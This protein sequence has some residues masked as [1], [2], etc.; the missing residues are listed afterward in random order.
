MLAKLLAAPG[1][2]SLGASLDLAFFAR[3]PPVAIDVQADPGAVYDFLRG[4]GDARGTSAC[5]QADLDSLAGTGISAQTLVD[6]G[7]VRVRVDAGSSDLGPDALAALK[8]YA[9]QSLTS[10]VLARFFV[11]VPGPGRTT[12]QRLRA[13][14]EVLGD[15]LALTVSAADVVEWPTSPQ[16]SNLLQG[17]TAADLAS[18]VRTVSLGDP[19]WSTLALRVTAFADFGA[20]PIAFVQVDIEY[21]GG[22]PARTPYRASLVFESS[23]TTKTLPE[24][25]PLVA[26]VRTYRYQTKIAYVGRDARVVS[27][28]TTTDR[29]DLNVWAADPAK[30]DLTVLAGDVDFAIVRSVVAVVAYEDPAAGR[31]EH[32]LTLTADVRSA[33]LVRYLDAPLAAP[34]RVTPTFYLRD[35]TSLVGDPLDATTNLV[36]VGLPAAKTL[37]VSLLASG[38]L[39]D[40]AQV[41]VELTYDD[42][43]G[44]ATTTDRRLSSI[45]DLERWT[46]PLR[47]ASKDQFSYSIE[48]DYH[49]R[50]PEVRPALTATGSQAIVVEV[51]SPPSLRVTVHPELVDFTAIPLVT[52]DLG[53]D[54]ATPARASF[55]FTSTT[56]PT[57]WVVPLAPGEPAQFTYAITY[58]PAGRDPVALAPVTST[59][60]AVVIPSCDVP[61]GGTLT[62]R[63]LGA[64]IDFA[65]V[66][67]VQVAVRA[68]GDAT[69]RD[70]A[71]LTEAAPSATLHL[72]I[73]PGSGT[74]YAYTVSYQPISGP[75]VA[76]PEATTDVPLLVPRLP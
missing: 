1:N 45:E 71:T 48:I 58:H 42:G 6:A 13:R 5:S 75:V 38:D 50:A 28:W 37:R 10:R 9:L 76:L 27:S 29:F 11:P 21:D 65:A 26:G 35:G 51:P 60:S 12:L 20:A 31:T 59:A 3:L 70:A 30:L 53:H 39:S 8:H 52:V 69:T 41:L 44:Y 33:S 63:V 66:R 68:P 40:V 36:P 72:P 2:G 64:A 32:P 14:A 62:I 74:Q 46:V 56:P 18:A 55:P 61:S 24:P 73:P 47:D 4:A 7:V 54:G 16:T 17:L 25:P 49:H 67:S 23:G 43:N 34:A 22:D 15:P 57:P 19:F